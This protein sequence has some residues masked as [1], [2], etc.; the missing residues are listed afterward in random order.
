MIL[1]LINPKYT[2]TKP[3][4]KTIQL[5]EIII[6]ENFPFYRLISSNRINNNNP[7]M[8]SN[9]SKIINNLNSN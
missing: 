7:Y 1:A 8:V 4:I 6:K 2:L 5:I 3:K 9:F